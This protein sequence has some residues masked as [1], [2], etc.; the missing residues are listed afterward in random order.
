MHVC[1]IGAMLEAIKGCA[2]NAVEIFNRLHT[3]NHSLRCE[4]KLS[5]WAQPIL[6]FCL[7]AMLSFVPLA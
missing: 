6:N 7:F 4:I 5:Y 2:Y 1:S 3:Y